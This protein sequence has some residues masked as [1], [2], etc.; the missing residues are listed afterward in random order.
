MLRAAARPTIVRRMYLPRM[1]RSRLVADRLIPACF[2]PL[3]A[4]GAVAAGGCATAPRT[5]PAPQVSHASAPPE[6]R[7][8][9]D[10][11][12]APEPSLV[13]IVDGRT[14]IDAALLRAPLVE[15]GGQTALRE[16]ILD[17]RLARR[18]ADAGITIDQAAVERE[19]SLLL[20][21]LSDDPARAIELLGE[22]RARQGLGPVRFAALLRRNAGLRALVA[23][24]VKID[25]D[26]IASMHDMLHGAKR[27]ARL[28]V[29]SSLGDAQR[30]IADAALEGGGAARFADL[31][32]ERSL[33]ESAAR[34]GLLPPIARRDPSYPQVLRAA[35]FNAEIG[36]ATAP[37]LDG[38][39]FYVLL[40]V[41]EIP[42]DGVTAAEARPRSERM[43]RLSR[44]RLLMDALARELS[45]LDGVTVFDRSFDAPP[46]R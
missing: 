40:A 35:L 3:L 29:L 37:V 38:G 9:T 14:T 43:L 17:T 45:A 42:A 6:P 28:A 13:A 15:L 34:G 4:L 44:E 25:E 23:R 2:T 7:R 41:K 22:V 1:T 16:T 27:V 10:S 32:V 11:G 20:E 24:D 18:L 19:Q 30:F 33:D 46:R 21:T 8:S 36:R 5:V 26:G 31:A 39:R 12:G